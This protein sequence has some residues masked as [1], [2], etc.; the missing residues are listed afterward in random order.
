MYTSFFRSIRHSD[1]IENKQAIK[2]CENGIK[3]TE[4]NQAQHSTYTRPFVMESREW[5]LTYMQWASSTFQRLAIYHWNCLAKWFASIHIKTLLIYTDEFSALLNAIVCSINCSSVGLQT[6]RHW[7]NAII[8]RQFIVAPWRDQWCINKFQP[9]RYD[10]IRS[11]IHQDIRQS[12][13]K[14]PL[15][16][17]I[18]GG[19]H[20]LLM[21]FVNSNERRLKRQCTKGRK[22][23]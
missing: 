15:N 14:S 1:E 19:T 12:S 20:R 7:A 5:H 4:L 16:A 10:W 3:S 23:R 13:Q 18:F 17:I 2:R 9:F 21:K 11:Q 8:S 6:H 22:E